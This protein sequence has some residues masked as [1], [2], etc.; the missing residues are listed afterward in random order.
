MTTPI[1][2]LGG[3]VSIGIIPV[4]DIE[5]FVKRDTV[6]AITPFVGKSWENIPFTY[7]S[8]QVTEEQSET[9]AGELYAPKVVFKRAIVSKATSVLLAKY[10][11][12]K[13]VVRLEIDSGEYLVVGGVDYPAILTYKHTPGSLGADYNG[14]EVTISAKDTAPMCLLVL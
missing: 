1:D 6:V 2:N 7:A 10:L 12:K 4:A 13:I 14:Y 9:E 11:N 5:L 8:V 3:I